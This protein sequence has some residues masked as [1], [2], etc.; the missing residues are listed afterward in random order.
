[1][2]PLKIA[3][4]G[5]YFPENRETKT[6]FLKRGIQEE[7]IEKLGVYERRTVT[8]G[9]TVTDL[10]IEAS[11]AAIKDAGLK[12][13]DIDLIISS[14]MLPEMVGIPNSNLLQH[15]LNAKNAAA[16]D[17][18]QACGAAIPS[19]LI[20]ANFMALGQYQHILVI[21]SSN[22]SVI[23]NPYQPSADF[24]LGDGAAAVVLTKSEAAYG[25]VSFAMQTDGRF[26][27]NC[28][29]R[30]GNDHE[31][32]Y[33]E[34]HDGKKLLFY[35]DSKGIDGSSSLFA[36]YLANN[37]PSVFHAALK[38]ASL[39]PEDI[40]CA[41]IHGN[42]TPVVDGWIKGMKV[43]RERFPLT[44]DRYGN[45]SVVTLLANLKEGLDKGMIKH[46]SMVALVSQGAG[47]SAGCIIMRW[48]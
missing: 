26:F 21:T 31:V 19:I 25:I 33:Y 24:V 20:A 10:E 47:F 48:D 30:V 2:L 1:M 37:G 9:Q 42:V 17:I 8:K 43:P 29:V 44:F 39:T 45:L 5:L 28:G 16:F 12:P 6:D 46:G 41:V 35:I 14:T 4:I 11:L 3:G 22:W 15:R 36:D 40:D 32:K 7:S 27:Y 18:G 34:H 13:I 23:S 38:K